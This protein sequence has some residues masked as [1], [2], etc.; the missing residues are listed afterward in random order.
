[1]EVRRYDPPSG[2]DLLV[3]ARFRTARIKNRYS[4]RQLADA[5]YLTR[6]Q[7][8]RIEMG[9]VKLRTTTAW[10]LCGF[11]DLNPLWLAFGEPEE[12]TGFVDLSLGDA[13]MYDP[14]FR[15]FFEQTGDGYA[16][17]RA[18]RLAKAKL[19]TVLS[20]IRSPEK[21]LA[22]DK[23]EIYSR[24]VP[25]S[26]IATWE[27]MRRL[28]KQALRPRGS[29]AALA[30]QFGITTQAVS[31]WLR[32]KSSPPADIALRLRKML[33]EGSL[34]KPS[35]QKKRAGRAATQ[36]APKTQKGKN[37]YEKSRSGQEKQ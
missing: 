30:R 16:E 31:H 1:M 32:D 36:P 9:R 20:N 37:K 6:N 34:T 3:G 18:D 19:P 5:L 24:S 23:R 25:P 21:K 35:N 28:L 11:L 2:D 29:K 8:N 17:W 26:E 27:E 15:E 14:P 10:L 12:I 22:S 13:E 4:Q 7:V 33:L